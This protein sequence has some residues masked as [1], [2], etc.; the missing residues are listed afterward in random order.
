MKNEG[1]GDKVISVEGF[2]ETIKPGSRLF[3][4][5]EPASPLQTINAL[6]SSN[7]MNLMDLEIVQLMTTG[8]FLSTDACE[9][10]HFRLKTFHFGESLSRE[11][12]YGTFDYIPAGIL[13]I[14]RIFARNVLGIDIAVIAVSPP[15]EKG[16]MSPGIAVDVASLAAAKAKTVV[17]EVNPNMPFT[18]TDALI[19]IGDV[20]YFIESNHLLPE[21][22]QRAYDETT[23]RIGWNISSLVDDGS[24]VVM[25]VGSI[26]DAL[27]VHLKKKKELGVLTNVVSDWVIDLIEGGV[28]ASGSGTDG[29]CAVITNSCYGTRRLYDYVHNNPRIRFVPLDF[30]YRMSHFERVKALVS[31][32][33]V[34]KTDI[35]GNTIKFH[36]RDNILSGYTSKFLFAQMSTQFGEG[37]VIC[38]LRS[39]NREGK[40]AIVLTLDGETEKVRSTMGVVHY[41]VTEYGIASLYGKSVRERV[42]ALID[43]AHPSHREELLARAKEAGLVYGDQIYVTRH[44]VK[45]PAHLET[46]KVFAKSIAVKFRPIKPTDEDMLRR[47]FYTLSS[48]SRYLRYFTAIRL[49]PHKNMQQYVNIDHDRTLCIVGVVNEEGGE[50]IVAEA[51]Y[52]YNEDDK[53]HEMGFVVSED[54]QRM[55][56][57]TFLFNYLLKIAAERGIKKLLAVVLPENKAMLRVFERSDVHPMKHFANG[58]IEVV[59]ELP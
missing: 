32:L 24:T 43:I 40:S 34:E 39:V 56:I 52:S 2:L 10:L 8:S 47:Q 58:V 29:E 22:P 5:S 21:R 50:H 37:K 3:L 33:N 15:N 26:F 13:D 30:L 45:Y 51:R 4:S 27:A 54:F 31:V 59:L 44:A 20:D 36:A 35:T 16:R 53:T 23:N 18:N 12:C 46:V 14:P 57:A 42:M 49:M 55:G 25:H 9:L 41:V 11:I 1:Y 17:A 48:N 38:A 28:L 7:R 6:V 19:S